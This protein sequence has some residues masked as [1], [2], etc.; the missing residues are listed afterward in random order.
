MTVLHDVST[1]PRGPEAQVGVC[2]PPTL[3]FGVGG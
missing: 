3:E 2:A 1:G